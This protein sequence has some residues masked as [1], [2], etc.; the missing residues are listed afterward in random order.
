MKQEGGSPQAGTDN[1]P[2]W[3]ADGAALP[4]SVLGPPRQ[5]AQVSAKRQRLGGLCPDGPYEL[6]WQERSQRE[7]SVQQVPTEDSQE[8]T[9][10]HTHRPHVYTHSD[11]FLVCLN[12]FKMYHH[13]CP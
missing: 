9:E 4:P 5:Q 11:H 2:I 6:L 7:L 1:V 13:S 8:H 3:E 10:E 12:I